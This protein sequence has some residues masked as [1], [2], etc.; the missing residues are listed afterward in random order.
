MKKST[1]HIINNTKWI[2]KKRGDNKHN[3]RNDRVGVMTL[4]GHKSILVKVTFELRAEWRENRSLENVWGETIFLAAGTA[5]ANVLGASIRAQHLEE[6]KEEGQNKM[7]KRKKRDERQGVR[8]WK[9]EVLIQSYA[10]ESPGDLFKAHHTLVP[11]LKILIELV[12]EGGGG[13]PQFVSISP[14]D[15]TEHQGENQWCRACGLS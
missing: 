7:R 9:L 15:S 14:S 3:S 13:R 6:M 8:W 4:E 12:W 11:S 1:Q 2:K 10:L 5:C